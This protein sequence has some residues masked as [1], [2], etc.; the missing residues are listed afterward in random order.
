MNAEK[1]NRRNFVKKVSLATLGTF[2]VPN[3]ISSVFAAEKVQ[4]IRLSKEDVILFQGDSITDWGR[5]KNSEAYNSSA[6]LGSGY[7]LVTAAQ[8]LWQH[9][10]LQLKIYNKGIS[11]NKVYQLAERWE[12]ECLAIKPGVLSILV[13]VNDFWHTLSSGYQGTVETY[14]AD[15]R[16]LLT[17]TVK[18]LPEVRL[19]ILEPFALKDVKAVDEKWY[20]AFDAYRKAAK[21][22]AAEFHATFI[23][24]QSIFD[25]A[26]KTAPASYW[27]TDG[28]HPSVAGEGLIAHAWLEA[29][30]G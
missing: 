23:P 13:G 6:N 29:V 17:T 19:I 12:K 11:G 8:L 28:V 16:K 14:R 5:D 7:P 21:D 4:K 10:Q 2:T 15:Y 9:P 27:T 18:A 25:Q 22:L 26:L 20:P 1:N 30:S 24:L 3:L